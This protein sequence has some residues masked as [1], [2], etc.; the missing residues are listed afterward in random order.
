MAPVPALVG[1]HRGDRYDLVEGGGI[2]PFSLDTFDDIIADWL[3]HWVVNCPSHF[4]LDIGAGA[5]KYGSMVRLIDPQ[6]HVVGIEIDRSYI[7]T[8]SLQ[9][10][11]NDVVCADAVEYLLDQDNLSAGVTFMGD[12]IEHLRKSDGLDL[13]HYLVYHC[14]FIVLTFPTAYK[15]GAW[16]GHKS[17]AHRSSWSEIDFNWVEHRYWMRSQNVPVPINLCIV[18]GYIPSL[19]ALL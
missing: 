13:L 18:K 7:E 5:G 6:A 19:G 10:I 9:M 2:M 1:R 3:A 12:V 4:Y 15:Q 14:C 17:E 16:E 8:Y 11:Y